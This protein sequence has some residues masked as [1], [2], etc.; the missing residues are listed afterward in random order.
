MERGL[1]VDGFFATS[2]QQRMDIWALREAVLETIQANGPFLSLDAALPLSKVA[3]F[4]DRAAEIAQAAQ[5]RPMLV[6]HLGDG[7]VHYAVVAAE[8]RAWDDLDVAGFARD[9]TDLLVAFGGSFSAEHGIGRGKVGTLAARKDSAQLRM[10][11]AIKR[12]IDPKGTLNPGVMF[13]DG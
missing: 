13:A 9:L 5:L 6:A 1:V 11:A 8:G 3:G 7:N 4:L 2:K 10:M 12:G